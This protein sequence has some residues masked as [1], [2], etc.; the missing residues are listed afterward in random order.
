MDNSETQ[1]KSKQLIIGGIDVLSNN[2]DFSSCI[3]NEKNTWITKEYIV[4]TIKKYCDK[5][6]DITDDMLTKFKEATIHDSYVKKPKEYYIDGKISKFIY[7]KDHKNNLNLIN[8]ENIKTT[9]PLQNVTYQRLELVG[10]GIIRGAVGLYLYTRYNNM[11]EGVITKIRNKIEQG[12]NLAQLCK[13]IKLNKYAIISRFMEINNNRETNESL[14]EDIFES[15]IGAITYACSF[16]LA[17]DFVY[18]IIIKEIHVSKMLYS[19]DNYKDR[20]L[21]YFHEQSWG[22]PIYHQL[23][24]NNN[25]FNFGVIKVVNEKPIIIANGY[26]STKK[27]AEQDA[28]KNA[29]I[30]SGKKEDSD[31]DVDIDED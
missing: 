7:H 10:D 26:G 13:I 14:L 23:A 27:T 16:Q 9:L 5:T 8:P 24:K 25:I 1:R 11:D 18:S 17:C 20:L 28:S 30:I 19:D 15:F 2:F 21:K 6:I 29:L 22:N 3:L 4:K 12:S 31:S